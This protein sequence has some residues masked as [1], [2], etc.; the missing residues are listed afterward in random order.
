LAAPLAIHALARHNDGQYLLAET[1]MSTA[2]ESTPKA[3]SADTSVQTRYLIVDTE[4]VPDGDLIA[5]VKYPGEALTAEQ[6]IAKAQEEARQQSNTGSDFLPVSFQIPVA[7]CVVRVGTDYSLLDFRCLDAPQF[8]PIEIVRKFWRGVEDTYKGANLVT[9][10]GRG[11]DMPLLE[12][13]AFR[14]GFSLCN[15]LQRRRRYNSAD[16][17]LMEFV[18][19]YGAA[20]IY[21]GLNLLA[22]IVGKPGKCG[23]AGHQVYQM[24]RDGRIAEINDYCLC[25]TLDTYFVFLRTRV[26]TGDLTLDREQQIVQKA[27]AFLEDKAIDTPVLKEYLANWER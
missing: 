10:N 6:A 3:A 11:F 9:F 19:N 16:L 26:L 2:I 24:H 18:T 22:K 17:D 27:R 20:R 12:L 1:P 15:H 8:R 4:S 23:V 5:Q 25:D 21:G 14:H 13:A 7:V